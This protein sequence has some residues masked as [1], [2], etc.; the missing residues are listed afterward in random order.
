MGGLL[1]LG[2]RATRPETEGAVTAVP[3]DVTVTTR[4]A[5]RLRQVA[6]AVEASGDKDLERELWRAMQRGGK[7]MLAAARWGA[8]TGLPVRG[9]LAE[10]VAESKFG[11]RTTG[12]GKRVGVRVV[13]QSGYDLEGMDEGL[14][15]HP[16][17][18]NRK[19]W[20]SQTIKPGWFSD[21][22]EAKAP[23]VRDEL[24]KGIDAVAAKLE[25]SI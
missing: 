2:I 11:V 20:V 21:A 3:I 24:V 1:S 22:E 13:G 6:A 19:V 5:D 9:G 18:G 10:R 17:R 12:A 15:R 14:I 23:E 7:P 4:G 8:R 16:V 25:A